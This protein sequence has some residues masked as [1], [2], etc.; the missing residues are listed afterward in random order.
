MMDSPRFLPDRRL[1]PFRSNYFR[2]TAGRIHYLDEG[3]GPPLL[4]LHGN[5]TWSFLYRGIVIRLRKRFRCVAVDYLG[6]GLSDHPPGYRYTPGEHAAAVSELVEDLGLDGL[7]V[8]GQDWGGPIG[9]RVAADAPDRVRALVQGNTWYWPLDP[10]DVRDLPLWAFS[11]AMSTDLARRLVV[12]R[13]LFVERVLPLGMKHEVAP[14]VMEHY[15]G[16][17][18]APELRAGVAEFARQLVGAE[19]WLRQLR[20]DVVE[21]LTEKPLL[22]TWGVDDPAFRP[23]LMDRFRAEFRNVRTVPLDARHFIQE[24]SPAEMAAALEEFLDDEAGS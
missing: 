2:A 15:R 8:V 10:A 14:E 6:F 11:K 21:S 13:N 24:D 7:T 12:E 22:L 4:F 18:D 17:L 3:A 16:P 9:M 1:Y 19:G 20:R 5:P 23:S